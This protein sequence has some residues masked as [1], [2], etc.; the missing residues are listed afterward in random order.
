MNQIDILIFK[1]QSKNPLNYFPKQNY[2]YL[3]ALSNDI[4]LQNSTIR[5]FQC[6]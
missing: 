4:D 5:T 2:F 3:Q 6:F 1:I